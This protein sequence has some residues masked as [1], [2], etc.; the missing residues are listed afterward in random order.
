MTATGERKTKHEMD[1]RDQ[2]DN[3]VDDGLVE[4][5]NK[6]NDW[7]ERAHHEHHLKSHVSIVL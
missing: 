4:R 7:L 6:R 2:G 1:G 3:E 5:S